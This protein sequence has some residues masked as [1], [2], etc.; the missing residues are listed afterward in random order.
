LENKPQ[1]IGVIGAG[2]F[3]TAIANLIAR[4]AEVLLYA[5][6]PETVQRI[7][8]QQVNLDVQLSERIT[9]TND[10][11]AVAEQC[12]LLFGIV[13]SNNFREMMISI[14]PYLRPYHIFVHG[15]KGLDITKFNFDELEKADLM[16]SH[17][18]TMSEVVRQESSVVRVGCL[19]GP[20]LSAEILE[21]QPT[22]TVVASKF[23]EVIKKSEKALNSE[24]F[25]VY[26][27][28]D[29][30]G[31]ELAGVFKNAYA[32][33]SGILAGMGMGKNIQAEIIIS[34]N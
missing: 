7:N 15:T 16:R 18:H 31:A 13:P 26:G 9:A 23:K 33:G 3:G 5:R 22:A 32:I 2:S 8:N 29:L 19:S 20:N 25:H 14:S 27:S 17:V 24:Q 34:K 10:I 6:N 11:Q 21:G 4:N 30:L 1:P 12:T 28:F